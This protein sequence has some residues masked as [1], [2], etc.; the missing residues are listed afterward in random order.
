MKQCPNYPYRCNCK[1]ECEA[2]IE[3]RR[4]QS[5]MVCDCDCH[6]DGAAC[7]HFI[8]C[9]DIY[10]DYINEDGFCDMERYK[11]L[12]I[13]QSKDEKSCH[14]CCPNESKTG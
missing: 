9:C 1:P 12:V 3:R 8:H 5:F 11:K 4:K 6:R 7:M 14:K 13:E 10:G 2:S